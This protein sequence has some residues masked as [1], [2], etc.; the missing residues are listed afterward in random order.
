MTRLGQARLCQAVMCPAAFCPMAAPG[1]PFPGAVSL[2][3]LLSSRRMLC[4]VL[5]MH[6]EESPCASKRSTSRGTG[7]V[8]AHWGKRGCCSSSAYRLTAN[9]K[10][11]TCD[12]QRTNLGKTTH[13]A[14]LHREPVGHRAVSQ[15][16]L[17]LQ[18]QRR[19]LKKQLGSLEERREP[20]RVNEA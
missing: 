15:A 18:K 13:G 14:P 10:G 3:T 16:T 2:L 9:Q 12:Q 5:P 6:W 19:S 4:C 17:L 11:K 7:G 20:Q 1:Q 8:K